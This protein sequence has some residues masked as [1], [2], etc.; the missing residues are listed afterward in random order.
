MRAPT[1]GSIPAVA[2]PD[3]GAQDAASTGNSVPASQGPSQPLDHEKM[4]LGMTH[5]AHKR[6]SQALQVFAELA[7]DS[8]AEPQPHLWLS[9]THARIR[10]RD[11][12]EAGAAEHYRRVLAIDEGHHEARKF[13]RDYHSKRRLSAIP[14]GRYF[15][16]K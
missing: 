15:L 2:H 8:H 12:D 4:K 3:A 13:V 1:P 16:K 6:F 11:N 10:L 5:L 14:F 7:R 9:L